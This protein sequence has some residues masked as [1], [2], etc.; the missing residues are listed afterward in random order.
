MAIKLITDSVADIP[1]QLAAQHDIIV[2]PL[3]VNFDDRSYVDG[4]EMD[5]DTFFERL[6]DSA[7]LPTTSQVPIGVFL[8]KFQSLL[9]ETDDCYFGL[10][11]SAKMSG[12]YIAA[13]QA[14]Q[15]IDSD[16]IMVMDSR[17]VSFT[18]GQ[19][20]LALAENLSK[21]NSLADVAALAERL[22]AATK[23]RYIVDTLDN[24]RRGGRLK[25]TEAF[26]GSML[27]IKPILT[28]ADG[29][30]KAAGKAR[31]RKKALKLVLDWLDDN[32]FDLSNK[33]VA[34]F[35]AQSKNYQEQL[36]TALIER[37]PGI[38]LTEAEIGCVVGTHS[39]PGCIALSFIDIDKDVI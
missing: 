37:Y 20:V 14:A 17:L 24:L 23:A 9:A 13:L 39:G 36:K 38:I 22:I 4:V 32:A 28:I 25:P 19:V 10:F 2:M 8:E 11:M 5:I 7:Q 15:E 3:T 34:I 21:A 1:K 16:R 30:L 27:N 18:F 35:N 29:E 33:Y 12:T 26:F 31:G 6:A